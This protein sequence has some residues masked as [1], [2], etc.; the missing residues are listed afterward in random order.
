MDFLGGYF[1]PKRYQRDY[2]K[3]KNQAS[4]VTFLMHWLASASR[5]LLTLIVSSGFLL[6][7]TILFGPWA[8]IPGTAFLMIL[9]IFTQPR[10]AAWIGSIQQ[11]VNSATEPAD[12]EVKFTQAEDPAYSGGIT[13][14]PG[15]ETIVVPELWKSRL[16]P[17]TLEAAIHRR[18]LAIRS[19]LRSKG[20]WLAAAWNLIGLTLGLILTSWDGTTATGLIRIYF[21]STIWQFIGLLL[22]PTLNRNAVRALESKMRSKGFGKDILEN[23]N[24]QTSALQDGEIR[25]SKWVETIF[26]P[27]PSVE[28]RAAIEQKDSTNAPHRGAW[29]VV[30]MMLY[31]SITC[32]GI[33]HRAVHCNIGRPDLWILAPAD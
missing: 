28:S 22:L 12:P 7:G 30:R 29:H 24:L 27:L 1:I 14:W 8:L 3:H 25:R 20:V 15:R 31:L 9:A 23:L 16:D 21:I 33:L 2:R 32:G 26:H 19:G 13:G 5:D 11:S 6:T 17:K 4:F 10:L 18:K